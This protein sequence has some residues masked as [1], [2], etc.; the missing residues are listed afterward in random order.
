MVKKGMGN[1]HQAQCH[2]L[3]KLALMKAELSYSVFWVLKNKS[4]RTD[5]NIK[6]LN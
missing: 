5:S 3:W 1:S 2:T 6:Y 4:S